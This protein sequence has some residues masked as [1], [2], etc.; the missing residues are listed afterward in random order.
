M[1]AKGTESRAEDLSENL[2]RDGRL[3]GTPGGPATLGRAFAV[4]HVKRHAPD[5]IHV[6]VV[7]AP[8]ADLACEAAEHLF[9][10][11]VILRVA[12]HDRAAEAHPDY[13]RARMIN[14]RFQAVA[15]DG[16]D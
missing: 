9:E 11:S 6:T 10:D 7:H 13:P 16:H 8:C 14:G 12:P 4:F 1:S 2:P 15:N 5:Q 3:N